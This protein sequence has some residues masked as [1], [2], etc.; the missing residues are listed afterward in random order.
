MI[1]EK[2]SSTQGRWTGAALSIF[3]LI[4]FLRGLVVA[5]QGNG[6]IIL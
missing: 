6:L 5:G 1:V 2:T 4:F 3:L